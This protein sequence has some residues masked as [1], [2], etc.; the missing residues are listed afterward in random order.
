MVLK[1]DRLLCRL[2][3]SIP[4]GTMNEY[5]SEH[6]R[7]QKKT[8]WTRKVAPVAVNTATKTNGKTNNF[9]GNEPD[10]DFT[11]SK[12]I[13]FFF[14]VD[15]PL[16]SN[17]AMREYRIYNHLNVNPIIFVPSTLVY[18]VLI[19]CSTGL[20]GLDKGGTKKLSLL[21]VY[22]TFSFFVWCSR[23]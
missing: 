6:L 21:Y 4:S 3:R 15:F 11:I 2:T 22:L 13:A 14:H 16:F 1:V 9:H 20:I 8:R 5:S 12:W 17:A 23:W 19:I 7:L 18:L 10:E